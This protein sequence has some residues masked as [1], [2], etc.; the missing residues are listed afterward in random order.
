MPADLEVILG[1]ASEADLRIIRDGFGDDPEF[2]LRTEIYSGRRIFTGFMDSQPVCLFGG[3]QKSAVDNDYYVWMLGTEK[4]RQN[5]HFFMRFCRPILGQLIQGRDRVFAIV[6]PANEVAHRWMTRLGF[7][8][9][10]TVKL[11]TA[12]LVPLMKL[13]ERKWLS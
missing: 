10:D 4:L 6:D 5:P 13:T 8:A 12:Q 7:L 2:I 9:V 3:Y 11:P 1:L